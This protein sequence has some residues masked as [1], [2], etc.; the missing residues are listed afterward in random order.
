MKGC[1]H[2][3][4]VLLS[5]QEDELGVY[6]EGAKLVLQCCLECSLKAVYRIHHLLKCR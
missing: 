4:G 6:K 5:R 1:F 2:L 3:A